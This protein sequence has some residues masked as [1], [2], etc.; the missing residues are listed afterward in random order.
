[1]A[2]EDMS[3]L[4]RDCDLAV[5]LVAHRAMTTELR[6]LEAAHPAT[7]FLYFDA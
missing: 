2:Y 7:R 3:A 5:V 4:L 6:S 1:M